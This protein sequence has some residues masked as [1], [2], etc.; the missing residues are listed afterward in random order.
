MLGTVH[1]EKIV[2]RITGALFTL[3]C[4]FVEEVIVLSCEGK[5]EEGIDTKARMKIRS[6]FFSALVAVLHWEIL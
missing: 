6:F 1:S 3:G 2:V 5:A 4:L